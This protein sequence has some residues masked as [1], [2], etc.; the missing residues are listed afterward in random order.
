MGNSLISKLSKNKVIKDFIYEEDENEIDFISTGG[1]TLNILFS[2]RV[3]GGIPV[4][5]MSQIAA[6]SS[7]G[8]TFIGMKVAKNAHKKGD[9]W[10]VIYVDTEMAFDYKFAK[11]VGVDTDRLLVVQSNQIEDIQQ[12]IMQISKELT[13]E[14][15][16]KVLL[17]IDSW[18]GLVTSKSVSNAET[19]NDAVDFTPAKKKNMLARLMTGLGMTIFIIN[20]IYE[21][22]VGET[23][24]KTEYGFSEIK[25][26]KVGDKVQTT[27]GIQEISKTVKYENAVVYEIELEDGSIIEC[28]GQHKFIVQGALGDKDLTRWVNVENLT[29]GMELVEDG[30]LLDVPVNG[31]W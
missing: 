28:T 18:G 22:M 2:G 4:G 11:S 1:I 30:N 31:K 7:L 8:K 19:G 26:L 6:P 20:Q 23:K 24:V 12:Q 25:D 16:S 14:E 9:D 10:I 15:R 29:N 5:K 27:D 3:D 21:C 17:I 13:K